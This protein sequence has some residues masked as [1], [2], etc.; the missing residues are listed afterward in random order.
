MLW[1]A[2]EEE[3]ALRHMYKT[4]FEADEQMVAW[5]ITVHAPGSEPKHRQL[6]MA[7]PC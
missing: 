5:V 7:T 3:D 6:P 2:G 4:E 1:H